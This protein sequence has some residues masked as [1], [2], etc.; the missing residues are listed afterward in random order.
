MAQAVAAPARP[1][2]RLAAAEVRGQEVRAHHHARLA[3]GKHFDVGHHAHRARGRRLRPGVPGVQAKDPVFE[4]APVV[5]G[6][7]HLATRIA[8]GGG[9]HPVDA[10]LGV[11]RQ[12][13]L[14]APLVEQARLAVHEHAALLAR[15]GVEDLALGPAREGPHQLIVE[16]FVNVRH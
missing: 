7:R 12:P 15:S 3:V 11:H 2:A 10:L 14:E 1:E 13:V 5:E 16:R 4:P 8:A 6:H 9:R